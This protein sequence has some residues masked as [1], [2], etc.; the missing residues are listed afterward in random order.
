VLQFALQDREGRFQFV[1]GIGAEAVG[2][3]ET[4]L[5]PV[6]HLIEDRDEP[7]HLAVIR[8]HGNALIQ[9]ARGDAFDRL[10]ERRD[11][12]QRAGGDEQGTTG[13]AAR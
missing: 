6:H 2:L 11:G 13:S 10:R 4:P 9:A 8:E 7:R 1:R 3:V 12:A 5:Q